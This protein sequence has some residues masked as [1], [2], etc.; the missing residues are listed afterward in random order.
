MNRK[1]L[2]CG[3]LFLLFHFCNAQKLEMWYYPALHLNGKSTMICNG[4]SCTLQFDIIDRK[5]STNILWSELV[6]I[7]PEK[8]DEIRNL[9]DKASVIYDSE[10]YAFDGIWITGCFTN[11]TTQHYFKL[12]Q[13]ASNSPEG[14]FC[15]TVIKTI[16][17]T[18][19]NRK[20]KGYIRTLKEYF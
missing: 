1:W 18:V 15:I 17:K 7:P 13:P 12:M 20:T 16:L 10:S 19:Q 14:V 9:I 2:L 4:D 8:I 5:D 3:L 11:D 6:L